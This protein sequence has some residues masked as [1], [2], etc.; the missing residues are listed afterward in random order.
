MDFL[1]YSLLQIPT[2]RLPGG[3]IGGQGTGRI[4]LKR[5]RRLL[6]RNA[7]SRLGQNGECS[8]LKTS[9]GIIIGLACRVCGAEKKASQWLAPFI[10]GAASLG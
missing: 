6:L 10:L 4:I 1:L 5:F 9:K 3:P 7:H 2:A 8:G